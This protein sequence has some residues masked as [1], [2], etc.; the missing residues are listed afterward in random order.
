MFRLVMLL[1]VVAGVSG[2][3]QTQRLA[4]L[5]NAELDGCA[6]KR[7]SQ[8]KI[9]GQAG[10]LQA[11]HE[12]RKFVMMDKFARMGLKSKPEYGTARSRSEDPLEKHANCWEFVKGLYIDENF[13]D[14]RIPQRPPTYSHS[15]DESQKAMEKRNGKVSIFPEKL[16]DMP[17]D[18]MIEIYELMAVN[19]TIG[20]PS[21]C[22][23][24]RYRELQSIF[25][26]EI[27]KRTKG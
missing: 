19:S 18:Q 13:P 15:N 7:M 12:C 1:M 21:T 8:T 2:C 9:N 25:G 5:K 4:L 10:Y 20:H 24:W 16:E 11:R 3:T 6:M 14:M 17:R 22:I 27:N 26:R 23:G